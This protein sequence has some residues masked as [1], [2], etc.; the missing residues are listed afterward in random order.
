MTEKDIKNK[1]MFYLKDKGMFFKISDRF[2]CGIPDIIGLLKPL[3]KFVAIELKVLPNKLT[4]I[5]RYI[6]NKIRSSGGLA[7][8]AYS[9][10]DIEEIIKGY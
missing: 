8:V 5:Q 1:A 2:Q 7:G 4:K 6:L 9:I 3:G 10:E